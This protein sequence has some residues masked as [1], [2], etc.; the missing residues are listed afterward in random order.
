MNEIVLLYAF[1]NA[2]CIGLAKQLQGEKAKNATHC[3]KNII[4]E[5][6]FEF[7]SNN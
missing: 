7:S 2:L 4:G 5:N 3:T 1:F 6:C